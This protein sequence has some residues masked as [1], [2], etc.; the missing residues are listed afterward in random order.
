MFGRWLKELSLYHLW[1]NRLTAV[2]ATFLFVLVLSSAWNHP[3]AEK[4]DNAKVKIPLPIDRE[5]LLV[6]F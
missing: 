1:A 6:S 3:T 2:A 5:C 4:P